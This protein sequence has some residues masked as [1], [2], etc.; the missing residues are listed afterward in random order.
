[1]CLDKLG[2]G[3]ALR[4]TIAAHASLV[5]L[6]MPLIGYIY[7]TTN[8]QTS[9]I[10]VKYM[11]VPE[12]EYFAY[13]L[14]AIT[15]FILIMCFPITKS[16]VADNGENVKA[17]IARIRAILSQNSK[18]GLQILFVGVIVQIIS[19]LLPN[20]V[21]FAFLLFFFSAFAGF[22]YVFYTP[23]LR[24]RKWILGLFLLFILFIALRTGMFTLVVYMGLTIFSFFLL[25][26][27]TVFWKKVIWFF[28][29]AFFML[30]L[31]T[32]KPEYRRITWSDR[33]SG[34]KVV[35]FAELISDKIANFNLTSKEA[36]FPIYVRTNQGFNVSLVMRRFPQIQPFDY[37]NN[38]FVV[39]I[40][41][42][43]PRFLW[44]DKPEAGG[45][46]NMQ[47]YAGVT[48]RGWSTN[49]GPLGE[50]Y[51]SFGK[52]GGII[53][54]CF[55]GFLIRFAYRYIFIVARKNAI[56]IFWIPVLFYQITYSAETDTLQIV[57]SLVKSAFFVWILYKL[58]PGWFGIG[59]V[60]S[61]IDNTRQK[62]VISLV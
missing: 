60:R 39:F 34:N 48:I 7:F 50:A 53:Y 16:N 31:Q 27:K 55:L 36:I 8:D 22:L 6:I 59:K 5:C 52:G 37:G 61:N 58:L 47:Y 2:N 28:I 18:A 19:P 20:S 25:E 44:S 10:W 26:R 4:E 56:I 15:G 3:I 38:L 62:Q 46:A 33:Y 9:R 51:G 57:N 21:Q 32:V 30:A 13:A 1:M 40:S 41:S 43:V 14:P 45:A 35:L 23:G 29:S 11:R 17:I 12:T 24:F 49:V 54:M 42:F